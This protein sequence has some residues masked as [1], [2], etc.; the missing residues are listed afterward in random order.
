MGVAP[1]GGWFVVLNVCV[2]VCVFVCVCV[3]V[4]SVFQQEEPAKAASQQVREWLRSLR[5]MRALD[6]ARALCGGV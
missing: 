4:C 3:R 1:T 6:W 5:R 2:F